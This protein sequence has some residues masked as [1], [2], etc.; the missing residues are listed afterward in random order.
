MF[1]FT[2]K[3]AA[4]KKVDFMKWEMENILYAFKMDDL[5]IKKISFS[6]SS[7]FHHNEGMKL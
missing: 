4:A 3:N 2:R 7:L 5:N 1:F 6:L